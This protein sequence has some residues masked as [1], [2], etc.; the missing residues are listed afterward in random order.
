MEKKV[1]KLGVVGVINRGRSVVS[2]VIG[3]E[4][5]DVCA[6]CDIKPD[7]LRKA[8]D[9]LTKQGAK[10]ITCYESYDE[11]L[12]SEIDAVF[13]ATDAPTHTEFA[14]KAL[15]AGKHVLSEIPAVWTPEDAVRLKKTVAAHPELKY[16]CAENCCYWA[17]IQA[18]KTM[19]EEGKFGEAVFCESEYLH[20]EDF[21]EFPEVDP[22]PNHWRRH[23]PSIRYLTHNLGPLLYILDDKCVSVTCMES[24][25]VYNPHRKA[26]ANGVALFKTAK[27]TIIKI[28]IGFGAYVNCDHNFS[29]YGT[30]GM[31]ETDRK[32]IVTEATCFARLSDIPG[33]FQEKLEIPVTTSFPGESK[34]GHGGADGK[35][36]RD[37][38]KCIINDTKPPIDVDLGIRMSLAG[39]YAHESAMNGGAQIDIPEIIL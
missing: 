3:D 24:D 18:W 22:T 20:A 37:F 38:I 32:K 39:W 21:R 9:A 27:G 35:M 31:I 5:V 2:N 23:M 14:V 6:I 4:N 25:I 28:F 8:Y 30:R 15:E 11:M 19:Y 17:F 33:T 16:M 34:A 13:I 7:A 36:V 10:N 1:V 12:A 29:I 26:S